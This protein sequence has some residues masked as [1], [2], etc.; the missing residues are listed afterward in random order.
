MLVVVRALE[1]SALA[2]PRGAVADPRRDAARLRGPRW[3][4]SRACAS[5]SPVDP[6]DGSC[7]VRLAQA[8]ELP[9]DTGRSH[10]RGARR[11]RA[12][13]ATRRSASGARCGTR[14]RIATAA[15]AVL[16][17]ALR[18]RPSA[19]RRSGTR[20][21]PSPP[22][23][24]S[25][26][27]PC[28]I[29]L[30]SRSAASP[31]GRRRDLRRPPSPQAVSPPCSA[32]SSGMRCARTRCSR[33]PPSACRR[34]AT[35]P[36]GC[37]SSR[38][39]AI[40]REQR[41]HRSSL[42]ASR[43]AASI[44]ERT[45]DHARALHELRRLASEARWLADDLGH[46]R[47]PPGGAGAHGAQRPGARDAPGAGPRPHRARRRG[48]GGD[49]APHPPRGRP[50]AAPPSCCGTTSVDAR[51]AC[52]IATGEALH[53]RRGGVDHRDLRASGDA[54]RCRSIDEM[55]TR[56]RRTAPATGPPT[57]M[58]ATPT[59]SPRGARGAGH[60]G[61]RGA[62]AKA[63]PTSAGTRTSPGSPRCRRP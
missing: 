59:C 61:P 5:S 27:R 52:F 36:P 29:G 1:R 56:A 44:H 20:S 14:R 19:A 57:S 34:S 8:L 40:A 17:R 37:P 12:D 50:P 11:A 10:H 58:T 22:C 15:H 25:T 2:G 31:D 41:D 13:R 18:R 60:D 30:I 48:G 43:L 33:S 53:P 4:L 23:T 54:R 26:T 24:R 28:A 9:A 42:E 7:G 16:A 38:P 62:H 39:D 21:M 47:A 63:G 49:R 35:R 45:G 6:G 32:P 3:P 55:P 46:R 51:V